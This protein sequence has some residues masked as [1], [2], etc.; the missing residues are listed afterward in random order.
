M[1]ATVTD[2]PTRR[3]WTQIGR[4]YY[5]PAT[6]EGIEGEGAA[7]REKVAA[8]LDAMDWQPVPC[9]VAFMPGEA[10]KA[11]VRECRI[12]RVSH[13]A[14]SHDLAPCGL[15]AVFGHYKNAD[16]KVYAVDKGTSTVILA[17]DVYEK[18]G[19]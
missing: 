6:A 1:T 19:L 3:D 4:A 10:I 17:M 11:M 13:V 9:E 8:A 7:T 16:V 14:I 12:P 15:V 18:A 2:K 5:E